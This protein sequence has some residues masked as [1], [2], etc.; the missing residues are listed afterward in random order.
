MVTDDNG[1]VSLEVYRIEVLGKQAV[2]ETFALRFT[3]AV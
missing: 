3:E 2:G 1:A